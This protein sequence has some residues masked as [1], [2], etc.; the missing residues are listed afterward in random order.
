MK[1]ALIGAGGFATEVKSQMG[2][3]NMLSFIDDQYYI[4]EKN[5]L[6]LSQFNSNEYKV[7]IAIG[8]PQVRKKIV[9]KLPKET[10]YFTFIHSSVMVFDNVEIGEG[11]IICPSVIIT[12][13]CKIGKHSHLNI[14]TTIGHDNILGD[15]FTTSPGVNISGNNKI[16]E[17]VYFGTNSCTKQKIDICDNTIIGLNSGVTKNIHKPGVYI[18]TPSRWLK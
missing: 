14:N 11:S 6:P 5:T 16:G 9:D 13:N 4:G 7:I 8:D 1:K 2:D 17:C 3:I 12:T 10:K 15:Y 18:G